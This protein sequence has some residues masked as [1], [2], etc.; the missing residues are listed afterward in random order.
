[1]YEEAI[2]DDFWYPS[3]IAEEDEAVNANCL[4]T[5]Y[6]K[7]LHKSWFR[8]DRDESRDE[9]AVSERALHNIVTTSSFRIERRLLEYVL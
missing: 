9:P 5:G 1:V 6:A 8:S 2:I 4:I 7:S 3:S